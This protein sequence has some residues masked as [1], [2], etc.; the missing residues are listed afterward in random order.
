MLVDLPTE[1]RLSAAS[2]RLVGGSENGPPL[3]VILRSLADPGRDL[4]LIWG[5]SQLRSTPAIVDASTG[6]PMSSA[7]VPRGRYALEVLGGDKATLLQLPAD[8]MPRGRQASRS[9]YAVAQ[10][11]PRVPNATAMP[12]LVGEVKSNSSTLGMVITIVNVRSKAAVLRRLTLCE[13]SASRGSTASEC[14]LGE[15]TTFMGAG[16]RADDSSST[17][18]NSTYHRQPGRLVQR[19]EV[20]AVGSEET[21]QALVVRLPDTSHA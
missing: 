19:F 7:K 3:L 12:L 15:H 17:Y 9:S 6:R 5:A 11:V 16:V 18:S 14:E 13:T 1:H 2:F 10:A 20:S 21:A 4:Q 8:F